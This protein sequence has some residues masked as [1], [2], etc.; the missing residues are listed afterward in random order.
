MKRKSLEKWAEAEAG[1][2]SSSSSFQLLDS[3][4]FQVVLFSSFN[5][6][7]LLHPTTPW[8]L[9][10]LASPSSLF[11]SAPS[12]RCSKQSSL[13]CCERQNWA[14][15]FSPPSALWRVC[16][17][18]VVCGCRVGGN[19]WGAPTWRHRCGLSACG[20]VDVFGFGFGFWLGFR[21]GNSVVNVAAASLLTALPTLAA[22]SRLASLLLLLPL[23]L[24]TPQAKTT[25]TGSRGKC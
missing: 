16:G 21:F 11:L 2:S 15:F 6:P 4:Q 25:A 22:T 7:P 23:L 13:R 19:R 10:L 20:V 8:S 14:L 3:T 24:G 17:R 12:S 9:Q 1:R 18:S 5:L